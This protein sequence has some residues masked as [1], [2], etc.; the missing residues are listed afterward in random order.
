MK[1]SIRTMISGD[2]QQ[3]QHLQQAYTRLYPP[4]QPVPA[5]FYLSPYFKD[6]QNVLCAFDLLDCL[7]AY[8]PYFVQK[9]WAWVEVEAKP[10]LDGADDVKNA[11]WKRLLI[12]AR[13]DG[14][15]KLCFQYYPNEEEAI[16][17]AEGKG[18]AYAYSIFA[19]QRDLGRAVPEMPVPEGFDLRR[20]RLESEA[21]QIAYLEGRNECFPEAPTTLEEWRYFAQTPQ[22]QPG[23]LLAAFSGER[24]AASALVYWEPDSPSGY[25]DF[26]FTRS[27]FRGRGLARCLLADALRY[28]QERGLAQ[29][30]L[31]VKAENYSALH[32][33]QALGYE[34]T[35]ESR[36]LERLLP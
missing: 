13:R 23:M 25:I 7:L 9:D 16:C 31:E 4:R 29:S 11:L 18:A 3:I 19:M 8:A 34:V 28:M 15:S 2:I 21:E 1:F 26:V 6:G 33:Y 30:I 5:E 17:F 36:V 14:V 27:E 24:L 35:A 12:L 10:D 32:T 22:W 20:C